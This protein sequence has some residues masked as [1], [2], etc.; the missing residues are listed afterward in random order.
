MRLPDELD[1]A[2]FHAYSVDI[3]DRVES[4]RP[5]AAFRMED[6]VV[7]MKATVSGVVLRHLMK[8]DGH[9]YGAG[10]PVAIVGEA[11]EDT[12]YDPKLVRCVRSVL[13]N[14]CSE[15]GNDY[16]VN[17]LVRSVRC[18]RCGS[19]QPLSNAFWRG[20]VLDDVRNALPPGEWG[21]GVALG[22]PTLEFWGIPPMCRK[23]YTLIPEDSLTD[24]WHRSES[25][26]IAAIE[27]VACQEP[28]AARRPPDWAVEIFEKLTFV[29]GEVTGE[30]GVEAPRPVVFKCPSCLAP[31]Q[32]DG[33]K[34]VVRCRYCEADVYLPD[35]LWLHLHPASMRARWWMIFAA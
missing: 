27:C 25:G 19:R 17:G 10:D 24:A 6:Q 9:N 1:G 14:R 2:E 7:V 22:G 32:I 15:C 33:K 3:G 29:F 12:G 5:I 31:L 4:G 21:G 20:S 34:R 8:G 16:P 18:T 30:G 13:L 35:D 26:E 28:H 11:G 23:C